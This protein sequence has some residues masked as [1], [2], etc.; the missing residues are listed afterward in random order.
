MRIATEYAIHL[1]VYAFEYHWQAKD[2]RAV[3]E[4]DG[5][6]GEMRTG[7]KT[8]RQQIGTM[9]TPELLFDVG[10]DAVDLLV[11]SGGI[12][13]KVARAITSRKQ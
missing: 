13:I 9:L 11:P 3:A 5:L 6:T 7:G 8:L 2:R 12:A 10:M 4:F 1:P